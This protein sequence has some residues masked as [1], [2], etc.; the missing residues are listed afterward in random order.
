[1][2]NFNYNINERVLEYFNILEPNFPEFLY[3]YINTKELLKQ[4]YIF[5]GCGTIYSDLYDTNFFYSNLDHSIGVALI[6]WHFTHDKKQTISGLFHDIATP[7]F[8]HCV[9]FINGDY[10]NQESTEELTIEKLKKSTDVINLLKRDNIAIEEIE[11]Y[12]I[13]PIADNDNPRVS[14]DRLEAAL[15]NASLTYNILTLDEVK[16]LY[17]D[18][19][20]QTNED[21]VIE[22]GFKTKKYARLL[23]KVSTTL[24]VIYRDDKT[25]YS[26][27]FIADILKN[28]NNDNLI[29]IDDLYELKET[30]IIDIIKESKYKDIYNSWIK[31]TKV[32]VSNEVPDNVY[33]VHHGAKVR[34]M[35]PLYKG[36]RIYDECKIAKRYIDDNL[37]YSM[38]NYV[39]IDNINF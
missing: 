26:M 27:Q 24:S 15:A 23:V 13:Y 7:C 18:L 9:D 38:D 14:A 39:Y 12:H 35:N 2:T 29:T 4:Q 31:S 6:I 36:K 25:R 30:E 11:D 10:M 34:Y 21:G 22:L 1:M 17:N 3:D 20:I 37:S 32:N 33:Y 5:L 8:K 28:L 19:E 16:E